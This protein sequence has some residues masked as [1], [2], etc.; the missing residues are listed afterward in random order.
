MIHD[1]IIAQPEGYETQVGELGLRLS[2]GQLRRLAIARALLK[3][4]PILML[5]EPTEGLDPH[6]EAVM[7]KQ[8]L[9]WAEGRS[10]L[11]VT[12]SVHGLERMDQILILRDG[13]VLD[14]GTHETLLTSSDSYRQLYQQQQMLGSAS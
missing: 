9:D 14:Q 13:K 12:H 4:A 10:L 3:N 11:L 8:I 6:T 5:D 7:M 2:E 1:F